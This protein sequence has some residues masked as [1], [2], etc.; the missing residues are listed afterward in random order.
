MVKVNGRWLHARV[1]PDAS[2]VERLAVFGQDPE[3]VAVKG[4]PIPDNVIGY[5]AVAFRL[6][7]SPG[8][9]QFLLGFLGR[10]PEGGNEPGPENQPAQ[11]RGQPVHNT[12]PFIAEVSTDSYAARLSGM[13]ELSVPPLPPI[14]THPVRAYGLSPHV[15]SHQSTISKSPGSLAKSAPHSVP[16]PFG[17]VRGYNTIAGSKGMLLI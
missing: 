5:F 17:L 9:L 7:C 16:G 12:S 13:L 10:L 8:P 14:A 15:P 1:H 11:R 4:E 6:C 2:R 3:A